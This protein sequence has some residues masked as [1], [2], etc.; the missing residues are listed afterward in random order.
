MEEADFLRDLVV[1]FGCAVVV[2]YLFHRL[3]QSPIV[4]FVITGI[5]IGPYGLSLVRDVDNV[6]TLA[7]VGLMILLFSLGL[8]FSLKKIMETRIAILVTGPLQMLLTVA[9]VMPVARYLGASV[10]A[11]LVYGVLIALSSTAVFMKIMAERG[12][13]DSIH[14]RIGLGI[15]IFQDLAT[16]P[17]MIAI[18][19]MAAEEAMAGPMVLSIAKA[20]LLIA[21]V[22]VVARYIF[23]VI[24][25]RILQTSSKELFLIAAIFLFLGIAWVS[26]GV[27]ISLA[28]GSFLAGLVLSESEY[29]HHIFAEVRP[30]R[31]GLNSLFFISLGMLVHP[32]YLSGHVKWILALTAAIVVG[33]TALTTVSVVASRIPAQ[34]A[35]LSSLAMAQIGEFSFILLRVGAEVGIIDEG[36]Y[37][38]LLACSVVSMV[39]APALFALSRKAIVRYSHNWN[40]KKALGHFREAIVGELETLK[41][42]VIICGFGVGGQN[43]AR[44]LKANQIPYV[45]V[46]LNEQRVREA[47]KAGERILFG[48]CTNTHILEIAG[49]HRARVVVFVISD[50]LGARLAVE[51][52]RQLSREIVVLTRTKY[53][54]DMDVLWDQGSTEVIA[55][56]FEASLEL[57]TRILRVYNA[58]RSLVAAE[59]KSIRDQRFGIFRE[60]RITVPRI[61]LSN[62]LDVFTETWQAPANY[63]WNGA[64][65]AETQ[66]RTETGA[67]ILGIIRENHTLN[68]PESTE[69]IFS[70]DRLVLS[71]TKEQ[72][73]TAIQML[74]H[75]RGLA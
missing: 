28:L 38:I 37:Q 34:S 27:G 54:A 62:D 43:I 9:A 48:D 55:E 18:P 75:G 57:M 67:M 64:S 58:P 70:G 5:I 20:L 23:P 3:K 6:S 65:I 16:I 31:D 13:V 46:D 74:T 56:E 32:S 66:L 73:N 45:V 8:E 40:P 49:I 2:V 12:E 61:R 17:F 35:V 60:R 36:P 4:G 24:L 59:I 47:R 44:T 21:V 33:K 69:R 51:A 19:L 29:G 30:F 22:V 41:D 42:H 14:G 63:F 1:V 7:T 11:S 26:S 71:G 15:C 53:V 72:L 10:R 25:S 52:A 39:I 50:P 68:N